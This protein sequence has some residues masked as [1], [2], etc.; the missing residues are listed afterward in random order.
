MKKKVFAVYGERTMNYIKHEMAK[1][2]QVLKNI[3]SNLATLVAL[4]DFHTSENDLLEC[5]Y[6]LTIRIFLKC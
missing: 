5:I 4:C 3:C 2:S 6:Y 1:I